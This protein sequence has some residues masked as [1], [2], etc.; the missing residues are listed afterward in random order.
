VS[1]TDVVTEIR[2]RRIRNSLLFLMSW[3]VKCVGET[4]LPGR[5]ESADVL[6]ENLLKRKGSSIIYMRESALARNLCTK[7]ISTI[8]AR[9]RQKLPS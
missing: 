4:E 1:H 7:R 9:I 8:L 3:K 5:G 2:I 6:Q